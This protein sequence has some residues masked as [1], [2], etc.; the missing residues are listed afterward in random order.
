MLEICSNIFYIFRDISNGREMIPIKMIRSERCFE[1]E[2]EQIDEPSFPDFKY[3]T[4]TILQQNAIQIDLRI[5][6][7]RICN[8]SDK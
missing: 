5:S 8:C 2:N 6:Q 7:M 4:K 1:D 3:I